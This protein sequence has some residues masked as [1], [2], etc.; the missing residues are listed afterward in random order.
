MNFRDSKLWQESMNLAG[1]ILS[2]KEISGYFIYQF[3]KAAVTIPSN[4]AGAF[5]S[6]SLR[7]RIRSLTV[8]MGILM[9]LETQYLLL[10]RFDENYK[11]FEFEKQIEKVKD[12]L[13]TAIMDSKRKDR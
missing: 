9:E 6:D 3:Q 4:I 8:S 7:E 5:S 2:F 12:L 10:V 1:M 13:S 11:N